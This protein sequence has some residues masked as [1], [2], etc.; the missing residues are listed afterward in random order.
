MFTNV[1]LYLDDPQGSNANC[2]Y[3]T[4]TTDPYRLLITVGIQSIRPT[5]ILPQ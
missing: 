2:G 4:V 5:V 3:K 1:E